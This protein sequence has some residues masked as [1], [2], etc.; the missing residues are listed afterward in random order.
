[1]KIDIAIYNE[2]LY[3]YFPLSREAEKENGKWSKCSS[4]VKE[5]LEMPK[6]PVKKILDM[7]KTPIMEI[8]HMPKTPVKET[9]DMPQ[10]PVKETLDMPQTPVEETLDMPKTPIKE[11]FVLFFFLVLVSLDKTMSDE[12]LTA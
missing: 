1:M 8:L 7:P 6:T 11:T 4:P 9:E 3:G 5:T 12:K 2:L 10:T